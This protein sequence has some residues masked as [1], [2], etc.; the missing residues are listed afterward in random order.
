M[1]TDNDLESIL[2]RDRPPLPVDPAESTMQASSISI[3][4]QSDAVIHRPLKISAIYVYPIKSCGGMRV[5][6]WPVGESGLLFDRE[7]TIVDSLGRAVTQ[8]SHPRLSLVRAA[9]VLSSQML[10][11]RAPVEFCKETLIVSI[12]ANAPTSSQLRGVESDSEPI[13]VTVCGR[14]RSG[15]AVSSDADAWFSSLLSHS[16]GPSDSNGHPESHSRPR[17]RLLSRCIDAANSQVASGPEVGQQLKQQSFSNQAPFL[18]ITEESVRTLIGLIAAEAEGSGV[19]RG[20]IRV[21][22]FRP[23]I[24]VSFST[25]KSAFCCRMKKNLVVRY[26]APNSRMKK[27]AGILYLST[28]SIGALPI[29]FVHHSR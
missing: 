29:D 16:T 6:S 22:N 2:T 1:N 8:K 4:D 25:M 10:I 17:Y 27:M 26:L 20:A 28:T 3:E 9:V 24:V 15:M 7:W 5:S 21:E 14:H 23:N 18:L 11:V 19:V 13:S 12:A